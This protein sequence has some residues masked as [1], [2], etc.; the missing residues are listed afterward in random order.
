M[1]RRLKKKFSFPDSVFIFLFLAS[2]VFVSAQNV[3]SKKDRIASL[4]GGFGS[5]YCGFGL[6]AEGG[7][8]PYS[9]YVMAGYTPA[10]GSLVRIPAGTHYGAGGWYFFNIRSKRFQPRAGLHL[11]WVNNY[12]NSAIGLQPYKPNIYGVAA[13]GGLRYQ[14]KYFIFDAGVDVLPPLILD[15][16]D[17]PYYLEEG[18]LYSYFGFSLGVGI[19]LAPSL[20]SLKALPEK[21]YEKTVGTRCIEKNKRLQRT[22]AK[23]A[24][25]NLQV[26]QQIDS[27]RTVIIAINPDSIKL[28]ND[29]KTFTID[30][31]NSNLRVVLVD[32]M[33][34]T[35]SV[36]CVTCHVTDY[37][38]DVAYI[39]ISGSVTV[40]ISQKQ[41]T[42]DN[43]RPFRV[44]VELNDVHF[45]A[46]GKV[47]VLDQ[48]VI[49]DVYD[50]KFCQA[51]KDSDK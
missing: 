40:I 37:P 12:Y 7:S 16:K 15:R 8:Y 45:R 48:V 13:H 9:F 5:T 32:K 22:Y 47:I 6:N 18:F 51:K 50:K 30:S 42:S 38:A 11:G 29:C 27:A 25:G 4:T 1:N 31:T 49:W 10:F 39:A 14:T 26:Y 34:Y 44:S 2:S 43:T 20:N 35:D 3:P 33:T 19:N 21:R 17:H 28:G 46:K 41:L 24:C 36:R 23:G